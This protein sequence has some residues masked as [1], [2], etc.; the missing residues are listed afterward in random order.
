M[1]QKGAAARREAP[2]NVVVHRVY[3]GEETDGGAS[4]SVLR[5]LAAHKPTLRRMGIRVRATLVR[6]ADLQP[7]LVAA[8]DK[9]GI[10]RLPALLTT[11]SVYI[12]AQ[13]ILE[14]YD[15][16]LQAFAAATG[17]R[18]PGPRPPPN[19]RGADSEGEEDA[20]GLADF[21]RDSDDEDLGEG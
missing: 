19:A 15:R 1:A 11:Q 21:L 6:A 8:L 9:K 20:R 16:N 12:G 4:L 13:S 5:F 17:G 18:A 7:R 10:S 14:L 2:A 3:V